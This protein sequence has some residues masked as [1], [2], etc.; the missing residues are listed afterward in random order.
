MARTKKE[1]KTVE[2]KKNEFEIILGL[3]ISTRCIGVCLYLHK[4][5]DMGEVISMT[6]IEPKVSSK[7]HGMEAMFLKKDIFEKEYLM[8]LKGKNIDKVII[9]EPLLSSNNANTVASL[10]RF[11]GMISDSV[12]RTLNIIP[13]YISS[14]DARKYA[15][16]ELMSI[17]QFD[18]EGNK[19]DIKA[20]HN[21]IQNEKLTL[22]ASYPWDADKKYIMWNKV[23][24]LYPNIEWLYG[25]NGEL[26][27]QNFDANDALIT[28]LA[29]SNKMRFG[30]LEFHIENVLEYKDRIT[31]DMTFWN[32]KIKKELIL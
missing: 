20:I 3:D 10:L 31:F 26:I 2:I 24:E 7:I 30:E 29:F 18:K 4:Q 5:N 32:Q 28:C 21:A 23:M 27:K 25:K 14:Y 12:F 6:H 19:Y 8:E 17:R 16:P 11:N 13:E 9:E 22:F 1:K 15:F